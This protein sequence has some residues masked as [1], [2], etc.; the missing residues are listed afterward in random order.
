MGPMRAATGKRACVGLL[1]LAIALSARSALAAPPPAERQ[2]GAPTAIT[3][4]MPA[5]GRKY[6]LLFPPGD[7]DDFLDMPVVLYLHPSGAPQLDR[8]KRDY[9]PMLA[10]RKCLM[11]LPRSKSAKMWLAGEEQ[12]VEDVLADVQ[13]RYSVDAKRVILLGVA[14]GGQAALFLADRLPE[15]FRAVIVVSTNP[16]V[17]R[18]QRDQ[19]FYPNRKVLKTCPYFVVNHI[20]QG[21]AL[22][23]WRQVRQRLSAAGASISIL[24]VTG[25]PGDYQPPPKQLGPWLDEV[26]AGKHP[27]PLPDPQKAAVARMF[28]KC[29]AALPKAIADAKPVAGGD[30]I[31][32][33]GRAFR[34]SAPLPASFERSGGEDEQDSTGAPLT[35]IR[36]EQKKWPIHLRCEA[37]AT[38]RPMDQV[39][40]AEE[41]QTIRRGML[42]QVYSSG[43]VA[44]GGRKWQWKVGSTTYPD[45]RRGWVSSL[46]I[47]AAAAVGSDPKQ[48]LT[49]VVLDETQQPDARELATILK[50]A[51]SGVTADPAAKGR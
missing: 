45:R 6:E 16:V 27:R 21:S 10:R 33:V 20:T 36:L 44:G 7:A 30:Q 29:A 26:L 18:G 40:S 34:L 12:F 49:V 46:F 35:Q 47:H 48:W 4:T 22:M 39:L 8:A 19:W 13:R 15:K 38:V 25:K 5:A 1:S 51:L 28:E 50:T 37:R 2:A 3:Q 17:I 9:W 41:A 23:Y 24:P 42:Y 31:V 32:K 43:T 11:V 14:G